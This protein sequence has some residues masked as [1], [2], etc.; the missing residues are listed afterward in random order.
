[1]S[2][3]IIG[4]TIQVDTG[5]SGANVSAL[6]KETSTLKGTLKDVGATV[7]G[8]GKEVG[9][10]GGNFEKLKG[11]IGA[12]PGPTKGLTEGLGGVNTAFN[13]L[14]ANPIIGVFALLAGLVIAL[15]DKFRKMEAVS[16]SLG[17]A[18]GVLSGIFNTFANKI[19]TPLIEGF[20]F[21]VDLIVK[22]ATF[23][24]DIFSPGLS[25]AA[26]RSGELTEALDDL[27]DAE[28]NSAI[29]RAESNRKLQEARDLANDANIPIRDRIK[30]LRE[31][32]QIEKEEFEKSIAIAKQR[33]QI[34]LEQIGIELGVRKELIDAIRNGSVEQLKAA[35]NEIM[36]MKNVDKEKL[37]AIDALIIQAEDQGAQLAKVSKRT[38]TQITSLEKEEE[39]K[40]KE[41]AKRA[42]DERKAAREK[43]AA[44]EKAARQKL[45]EFNSKLLQLQQENELTQIKDG[46]QKELRQLE[47]KLQNDKRLNEQA[48]I[49]KRL[50]REQADK[51]NA[52]IQK[53]SDQKQAEIIEKQNK[54]TAAKEEAFQKELK[55]I[56][57]RTRIAGTKEASAADLEQLK[58]LQEERLAAVIE[59]LKKE[60]E[61]KVKALTRTY[62]SEKKANEEAFKNKTITAEQFN[63]IN[64]DLELKFLGDK[65]GLQAQFNERTLEEQKKFQAELQSITSKVT[66]GKLSDEEIKNI[67]EQQRQVLDATIE[68]I[69]KEGDTRKTALENDV[70]EQRKA[71]Q[72]ALN[73]KKITAAEFQKL[74]IELEQKLA[75]GKAAIQKQVNDETLKQEREFQAVLT[76]LIERSR[77]SGLSDAQKSELIQLKIGYEEKIQ[78]AI[79]TYKDDAVKLAKVKAELD[80]ELRAQEEKAQAK[81]KAEADKKKFEEEEKNLKSIVDD[82]ETSIQ[83]KI[84]AVEAEQ[85]LFQQAFDNKI[86]TEEEYNNRVKDLA[87]KRMLIA[88]LETQ[89]KKQ[90]TEEIAGTLNA[91][92]DIVGKQTV[93]GKALGIATALI[94]TYQGASEALKQKSVL[95]SPFDVVAKVANVATVIATGLKSVKAITSVQVPGGGG[96][97]GGTGAS[98]AAP[99]AP[100]Q[101]STKLNPD[102]INNIGNAAAGGVNRTAPVRAYVVNGDI[103]SETERDKRLERAATLGG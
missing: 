20:T 31:A 22:S 65:A 56:R 43:A 89:H 99:I 86:L 23:I 11:Q 28:A 79:Q 2:E 60:S 71:N 66:G 80:A 37:K 58:F 21:L 92:A 33:A 72:E 93:A 57:L 41:A 70:A 8:T 4:A 25:E 13:L 1:M 3:Q 88:E 27:N 75:S 59:G 64:A 6:N 67:K 9:L 7:K 51:L 10:A 84:E 85:L 95:P 53:L 40:R 55:A 18:F 34:M 5:N 17:K 46:Y 36:A 44:E 35:R 73:N 91:L 62:E 52:E 47:I 24:A 26:K 48:V 82:P 50:T 101:T 96:A 100:T 76:G 81:F 97:G 42:S 54:E 94:N 63:K 68:G 98:P 30:A 12:L 61:E 16:D 103:Q 15:F 49:D 38:N 102:D 74:N 32:A 78:L 69:K 29:A 83:A 39:A 90:Q 14:R 87:E 19:L 45:N 77:V